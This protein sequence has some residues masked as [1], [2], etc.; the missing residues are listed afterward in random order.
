[1]DRQKVTIESINGTKVEVYAFLSAREMQD[2][3][4]KLVGDQ[5][6][7]AGEKPVIALSSAIVWEKSI[8]E[9]ALISV[10]D[11]VENPIEKLL[12]LSDEEYK[13]LKTKI[14]AQLK[15]NLAQEK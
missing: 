13:D 9:K 6:A 1:M 12:D 8:L 4:L 3:N 5:T 15:I 2:V 10:N 11:V 14:F 7:Q